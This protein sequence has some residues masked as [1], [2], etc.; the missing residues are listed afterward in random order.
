MTVV[1][2][3]S[4]FFI[5]VFTPN[6]SYIDWPFICWSVEIPPGTALSISDL[7]LLKL[8]VNWVF[9]PS[10]CVLVVFNRV[11]DWPVIA[12][13]SYVIFVSRNCLTFY[14]AINLPISSP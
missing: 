14:I 2:R 9:L 5:K 4:N 1:L 8:S 12:F 11:S 13:L 6:I 3:S 10:I 7:Y